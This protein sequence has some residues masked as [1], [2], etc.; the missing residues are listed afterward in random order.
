MKKGLHP[1]IVKVFFVK[2]NGSS[3]NL[4]FTKKSVN[5]LKKKDINSKKYF[6]L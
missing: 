6:F 1:K 3:F 5:S 4:F 2:K